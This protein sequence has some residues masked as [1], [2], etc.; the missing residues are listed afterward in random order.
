[1]WVMPLRI[2]LSLA[3]FVLGMLLSAL[4]P[5]PGLG[6]AL[7]LCAYLLCGYD[8]LIGAAKG[9]WHL[10]MLD[11]HFLMSFASLGAIALGEVSE[12]VAVM[13]FYQVGEYLQTLA[14]GKSRKSIAA[15]MDLRPDTATREENGDAVLIDPD[16][17]VPGDILIV[18]PGEK[19]PVDGVL[20]EG[21][22]NLD[23][24]ALTGES[25]PRAA[26]A[27]ALL[28]GGCVNLT[29]RIRMRA[30][31]RFADS[32]A[33]KILALVT[34]SESGKAKTERFLTKFARIYTPAVVGLA[35]LLAVIPSLITR[36]PMTWIKRAL[37]FLVVSCPCALVVSVPL[38]FF[39]GIGGA[40]RRG[41]LIKGAQYI[42]ALARVNAV[43]LDKTGTLTEGRF[44]VDALLPA[45]GVRERDL[46]LALYLA[47]KEL[48]HPIARCASAYAAS[49][50]S[51]EEK[52]AAD[53]LSLSQENRVGRGVIALAGKT[54]IAAGSAALMIE[55]CGAETVCRSLP[56]GKTAVYLAENR[57]YLGLVTLSDVIKPQAGEAIAELHALGVRR[58]TIL[59]GDSAAV[60][61]AVRA[62]TGADAVLAS[63]LPQDKVAALR[64]LKEAANERTGKGVTLLFAGD[65]INDAPALREAHVGVAMGAMGSDAAIEAADVVLMDDDPKRIALAIRLSRRTMRIAMQN[66]LFSIAVKL[67]I[68]MLGA[69]GI[70]GMW[71][72]VFADVGVCALAVLNAL[73]AML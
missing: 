58:V 41:I 65:G 8:V 28:P 21:E 9:L 40:S 35:L 61:D 57:R 2:G 3:L 30:Q 52:A 20:I 5:L 14:V 53:A 63:L 47:E 31:A 71:L 54:R 13:L 48:S 69:L 39:G 42:E 7:L 23:T 19:I 37:T 46:L 70:G 72:A 26:V 44:A 67:V 73:R 22:T 17:I 66:I 51:D 6:I 34:N 25:L 64:A 33:A 32:T 45:D 62:E 24:A 56:E 36:D 18:R 60:G 1:M 50:L 38:A 55:E 4:I 11:E 49:R 27:G 16:A 59:T 68:L 15:L 10:R 29:G 12:A 43:A